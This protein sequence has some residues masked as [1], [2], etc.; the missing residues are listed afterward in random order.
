MAG[1]HHCIAVIPGT[2][3]P[4]CF[5]QVH[6]FVHPGCPVAGLS[7]CH[8]RVKPLAMPAAEVSGTSTEAPAKW[9]RSYLLGHLWALFIVLYKPHK[10]VKFYLSL[11][12]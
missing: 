5:T 4:T 7:I 2:P 3:N 10:V 8:C 11:S 9:V 6:S 12:T 1:K